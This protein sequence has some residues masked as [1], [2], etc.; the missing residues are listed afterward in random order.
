M[1]DEVQ[2]Q[3]HDTC[4]QVHQSTSESPERVTGGERSQQRRQ[5]AHESAL[6]IRT[7]ASSHGPLT[8]LRV[9]RHQCMHFNHSPHACCDGADGRTLQPTAPPPAARKA[10]ST[11]RPPTPRPPALRSRRHDRAPACISTCWGM[12]PHPGPRQRVVADQ[13]ARRQPHAGKCVHFRPPARRST[14]RRG[15]TQVHRHNAQSSSQ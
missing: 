13:Q 4:K 6:Y 7:T 5:Q 1:Q 12:T 3:V 8:I 11:R 14:H 2:P 10:P 15:H 9:M